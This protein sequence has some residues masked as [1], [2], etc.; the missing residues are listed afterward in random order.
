[1]SKFASNKNKMPETFTSM[2]AKMNSSV[3]DAILAMNA[4][5]KEM[6]E[7]DE[8]KPKEKLRATQD[9]LAMYMRLE[10]EIQKER[11]GREIMK[12]RKL[13]TLIKQA[14]VEDIENPTGADLALHQSKFSPSMSV[15]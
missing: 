13:N 15:N 1:M 10:N 14:Q 9:Y 8:V 6:C 3:A 12:Q 11:E 2:K 5:L 4:A 7:D